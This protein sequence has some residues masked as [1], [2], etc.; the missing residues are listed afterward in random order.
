MNDQRATHQ[1]A[2]HTTPRAAQR[3]VITGQ[4]AVTPLGHDVDS[5]WAGL[6]AG[7]SAIGPIEGF[8]A[9]QFATNFGAEVKGFEL[10]KYLSADQIR[11][12]MHAGR[13]TRFA[14]ASA[15]QA[16]HQAGLDACEGLGA[17]RVGV[18]LG[19]G[20]GTPDYDNFVEV[21]LEGWDAQQRQSD[22]VAW[23]NAAMA[24][25]DAHREFEQE[26]NVAVA[27]V[28]ELVGA[29]GPAMNCMTACA[30]STQ[31]I[32]EAA[33]IIRR[34]DAEVMLAG[35][36]HS[37]LHP[38]G[39]SG[40]MRLTAMSTR[41]DDPQHASRP[42]DRGRDG[43]VM[44]EGAG[45]VVLESLD[46]ALERGATVLAEVSGFGSSAD[47]FRITDMHPEGEGATL[48]MAGAMRQAGLDPH[49][50]R[51]D[52]RPVVDYISA[53]G[54]S[55]KENDSVETRAIKAL[56]GEQ[57]GS[58][59]VSS[60]KSMMGHLIQAAGAVEVIACVQAIGTGWLPPTMHVEDQDPECDLDVVP[61]AAR[62]LGTSE[63]GGV[64]VKVCL[65]N[66]FG[67]GGQNDSL[68]LRRF[69]G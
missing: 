13:S 65:T 31:A 15:Q 41:R 63:W 47:A 17:H 32:G 33:A 36:C 8:E 6:L 35:G 62:D 9:G 26:P 66:S 21:N 2:H 22:P 56:F 59:V 64:G 58:L 49:A 43:F 51:A 1:T 61:N 54:T 57:A 53:H 68:I 27:H 29:S 10:E 18:Y 38:L 28:A 16:W 7:R 12:H 5:T 50:S 60:I 3:V 19:A 69:E 39:M 52:G 11:A 14:L 37:M 44:G 34:G 42:F 20:E 46:H 48:A 55:T 67:F 23:A 4:G 30:A 25:L 24:R 40:F 45:I